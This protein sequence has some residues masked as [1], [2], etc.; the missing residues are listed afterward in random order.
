M[1]DNIVH[2]KMTF[3]NALRFTPYAWAKMIYMRDIGST[4]VAGYGI[5]A[6]EDPLLIT[7]FRLVKQECTAGSFDLDPDD[8]VEFM[9]L[10]A[11][12]GLMPWQYSNI[13]IHTHP[14]N[15]PSPSGPDEDNFEKSFSHPNWA[16]MFIIADGGA[17]YCRVKINVGPG[18][19]K[20]IKVAV[21]W[22]MPFNGSDTQN[23]NAEYTDKVIK[24]KIHIVRHGVSVPNLTDHD[25]FPFWPFAN[26]E[27]EDETPEKEM[28]CLW[29]TNGYVSYW[30]NDDGKWYFYDPIEKQWYKEDPNDNEQI[31]RIKTP[32]EIWVDE[33]IEWAEKYADERK[34]AIEETVETED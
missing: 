16:I 1:S 11:D 15:S 29:D 14:G 20:E 23:W 34:L 24:K 6:T 13:L 2:P 27:T 18:V 3:G 30:N 28:D 9:E 12:A 7:D 19:I 31:T 17:T 21:D 8:G 4:E 26:D 22:S 25:D 33:V 32:D 10:M 5:T